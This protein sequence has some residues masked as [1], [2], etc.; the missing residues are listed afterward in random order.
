MNYY[1]ILEVSQNA[2]QEVLKAA[3]KSLMQ[4]YHPDKNPGNV[5]AAEHSVIVVQ[6]YEILSDSSKRAAYD[7]ELKRQLENLNN[8]RNRARNAQNAVPLGN[9]ESKS[10]GFLWLLITLIALAIWFV[11]LPHGKKQ[12][13]GSGAKEAGSLPGHYQPDTQQNKATERAPRLGARTIPVFI[14]DINVN[15]EASGESADV[16]QDD[17]GYVLTIQTLGVVVG[18]FDADKFIAFIEDNKKYIS[19]KLAAKL[20]G[21]KYEM[22][23]KHNGEPYLKQVILD[24]IGEITGTNRFEEYPSADTEAPAHYGVVDILLPESFTVKSLKTIKLPAGEGSGTN[25]P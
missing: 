12:S 21:I 18:A 11:W 3:Y 5:E 7:I 20:A 4:R 8:I 1:E 19:Q 22:L 2:S 13:S 23:M 25:L 14:K 17:A 10:Y 24:S 9:T 6:A 15:L 16:S